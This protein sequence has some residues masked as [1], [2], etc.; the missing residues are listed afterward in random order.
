MVSKKKEIR[1]FHG[2]DFGLIGDCVNEQ[3]KQEIIAN[4]KSAYNIRTTKSTCGS[5]VYIRYKDK[6][7]KIPSL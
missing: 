7:G 1:T 5:N 3:Q 6:Q 4:Y 2:K